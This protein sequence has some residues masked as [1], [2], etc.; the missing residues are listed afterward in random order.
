VRASPLRSAARSRTDSVRNFIWLYYLP[1]FLW[2]IYG[3]GFAYPIE[4]IVNPM[5][6]VVY[7]LWVWTPIPAT[8]VALGG[9]VLRHGGSPADEITGPLLRADFLGLCMQLGGHVC[10]FIVLAVYEVT[11]IVGA[12]WGQPVISVF[13][14]SSYCVGVG[15]LAFQCG[16]KLRRG[17]RRR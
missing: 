5:G 15:V 6:H 17:R 12:Y 8:V 16:Y 7:D 11:G 9:L 4:L 3:S 14:I 2:G 1:F 13:L 10:M